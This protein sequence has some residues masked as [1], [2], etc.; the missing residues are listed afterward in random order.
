MRIRDQIL[1]SHNIE[2]LK[3]VISQHG[4]KRNIHLKSRQPFSMKFDDREDDRS[5]ET[6]DQDVNLLISSLREPSRK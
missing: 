5:N 3:P 2:P 1:R 6:P 4:P